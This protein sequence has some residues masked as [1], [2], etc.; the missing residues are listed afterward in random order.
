[1]IIISIAIFAQYRLEIMGIAHDLVSFPDAV[2]FAL[3]LFFKFENDVKSICRINL[4]DDDMRSETNSGFDSPDHPGNVFFVRNIF[5]GELSVFYDIVCVYAKKHLSFV[6][7]R[8]E[9][10]LLGF[11]IKSWEHSRRVSVIHKLPADLQI[12]SSTG[13]FAY[14]L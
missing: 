2:I 4:V 5:I 7:E 10:L 6:L 8:H 14:S 3:E 1:M 9:D 11:G 13:K 12:K